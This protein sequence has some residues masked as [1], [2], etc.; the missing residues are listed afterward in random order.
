MVF[1]EI[2]PKI[3]TCFYAQ[4]GI[5]SF[6]FSD[7]LINFLSIVALIIAEAAG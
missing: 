2:I 1:D 4:I 6:G 3:T 7:S 5:Y